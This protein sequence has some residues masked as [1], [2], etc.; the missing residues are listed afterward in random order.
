MLGARAAAG[1][2][3]GPGSGSVSVRCRGCGAGRDGAGGQRPCEVGA[4]RAVVL[5][6]G[7]R[8]GYRTLDMGR[9]GAMWHAAGETPGPCP[10]SCPTRRVAAGLSL[11]ALSSLQPIASSV[12]SH[13][14]PH[15]APSFQPAFL[16]AFPPCQQSPVAAG[17]LSPGGAALLNGADCLTTSSRPLCGLA[18][19]MDKK[20]LCVQPG[21]ELG[22]HALEFVRC[23]VMLSAG[24]LPLPWA[25]IK[26]RSKAGVK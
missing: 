3:S 24:G 17:P 23:F 21:L 16:T 9:D 8:G 6:D 19:L 10:C 1:R 12:R 4:G 2:L 22:C 7:C 20:T 18:G 5:Q 25:Y 13:S 26:F 14:A 15:N 11:A